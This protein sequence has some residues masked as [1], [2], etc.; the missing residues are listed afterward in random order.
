MESYACPN[1]SHPVL[2]SHKIGCSYNDCPSH[3]IEDINLAEETI[4][5]ACHRLQEMLNYRK[6]QK[7]SFI[8]I[9]SSIY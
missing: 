5:F 1:C 3:G 9:D 7:I 4:Q 8:I 6:Q 2:P